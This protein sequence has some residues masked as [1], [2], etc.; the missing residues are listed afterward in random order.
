MMVFGGCRFVNLVQI[1]VMMVLGGCWFVDL[2]MMVMMVSA[3]MMVMMMVMMVDDGYDGLWQTLRAKIDDRKI[4][5]WAPPHRSRSD[6]LIN[7]LE[8]GLYF[9]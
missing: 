2:V 8:F 9:F 6:G 7:Y 4:Q 5:I 3:V 1:W